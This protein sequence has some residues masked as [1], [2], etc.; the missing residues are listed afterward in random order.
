[1]EPKAKILFVDDEL[2]VIYPFAFWFKSQGFAVRTASTCD[3]ALKA[4]RDE[5]PDV[6]FLDIHM[7]DT[8]GF[9]MLKKIK[10]I[11]GAI[12][13][14]MMSAYIGDNINEKESQGA[15]AGVFYK[16]DDFSKALALAE[17]AI[18]RKG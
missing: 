18:N 15:V 3:E 1:M 11:D 9:A 5:T 2:D 14:V 13:V 16:G 4:V 17:S 10:A 7:P 6:V 12:S 8:D